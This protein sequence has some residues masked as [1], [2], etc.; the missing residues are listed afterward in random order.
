MILEVNNINVFIKAS[1][2]L[3]NVSISIGEKEV[4]CLIGRN[5]AGKTTTLRSVM[6]F[7]HPKSGSI[8]FM[9]QEIVGVEPYKI[10]NM[11][12]GF[13]PEESGILADLTT[14]E[15]IEI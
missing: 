1:H 11:G 3:R 12:I 15:N 8:T 9:G 2:I 6:G 10:A 13:A 4:V 7:L 14:F 5:G